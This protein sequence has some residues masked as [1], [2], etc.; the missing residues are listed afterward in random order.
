MPYLCSSS[1]G[2]FIT[3]QIHSVLMLVDCMIDTTYGTLYCSSEVRSVSS[4]VYKAV[5]KH[6]ADPDS[7]AH[8]YSLNMVTIAIFPLSSVV[9]VQASR[10]RVS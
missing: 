9:L 1:V 3:G 4:K 2:V 5:K 7:I 10:T 8:S 6:L